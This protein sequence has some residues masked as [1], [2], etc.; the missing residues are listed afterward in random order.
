MDSVPLR[1]YIE[2]IMDERQQAI[3]VATCALEKRLEMLN[4]LRGDVMTRSEYTQAHEA[5]SDKINALVALTNK[6]VISLLVV[7]IAALVAALFALV[8]H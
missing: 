6:L 1:E 3:T 5:L 8:K 2:K 4:E 7:L